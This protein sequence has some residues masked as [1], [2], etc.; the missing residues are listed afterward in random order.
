LKINPQIAEAIVRS[1]VFSGGSE[2]ILITGSIAIGTTK[3]VNTSDI[4]F[5]CHYP[6][7]VNLLSSWEESPY[8]VGQG[9]KKEISGVF[10]NAIAVSSLGEFQAWKIATK[11]LYNP[12][13]EWHSKSDRI[14]AF[15]P[16]LKAALEV[17]RP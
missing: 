15:S 8:F 16:I 5:V 2:E 6:D 3:G 17:L 11:A 13:R 7:F 1:A 14:D 10:F 9:Y 12:N 4:D